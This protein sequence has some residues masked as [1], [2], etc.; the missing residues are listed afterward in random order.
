MKFCFLGD[1]HSNLIRCLNLTEA[2]PDTTVVQIG[3]LGV[4]FVPL[5]VFYRLP[6]NF[7]FFPGNHDCRK[8]SYTLPHCLGAYGEVFGKF[9][10]VSGADSI[11]KERRIEGV[12]WWSD[13][14]LTYR[15]AEDCLVK[16]EESTVDVLVTHDLPQ[17]FAEGYKLIYDRTL[18]RDLLQKMIEVRKPKLL[19]HGHH[20]R[21][22]RHEFNGVQ[23]VELGIDE[24]YFIDL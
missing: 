13:E 24:P 1:V 21:S 7:Y 23:V 22:K 14:E 19:I 10:F 16:W 6:K 4:G 8:L 9:F 5:D 12:S 11:D 3:D 18:T 20:H 15:E 17:S 2:Y